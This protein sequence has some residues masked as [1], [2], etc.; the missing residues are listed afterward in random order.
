MITRLRGEGW[1]IAAF[2]ANELSPVLMDHVAVQFVNLHQ[3][4]SSCGLLSTRIPRD[5]SQRILTERFD[6]KHWE[7]RHE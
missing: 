1:S 5:L 3:T 7:Y 6:A 2:S 4:P